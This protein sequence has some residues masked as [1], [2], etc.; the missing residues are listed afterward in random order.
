M[1]FLGISLCIHTFWNSIF[2]Y[3]LLN[4]FKYFETGENFLSLG[5]FLIFESFYIFYQNLTYVGN[6][7]FFLILFLL[8]IFK[9]LFFYYHK[10]FFKKWSNLEIFKH[11]SRGSGIIYKKKFLVFYLVSH[12][13]HFKGLGVFSNIIFGNHPHT[14]TSFNKNL[15]FLFFMF[16]FFPCP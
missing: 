9:K 16:G 11:Y 13:Y 10:F 1:N 8:Y 2:S 15:L 12:F 7:K 6:I 14:P 5:D 3:N 4:F